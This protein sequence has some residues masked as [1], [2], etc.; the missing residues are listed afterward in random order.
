[1]GLVVA[2][3]VAASGVTLAAQPAR[4]VELAQAV[5]ATTYFV[6]C[7][8][9]SNGAGT[10]SSPWNRLSAV[11][12]H[13]SFS[14]GDRILLKR[15]TTCRGRLTPHGSGAPGAQIVI[16]AYGSGMLPT[17]AGG[18]TPNATG[19]IELHNQQYWTLQNLHVTNRGSAVNPSTYRSGVLVRNDKGGRLKGVVIRKL[20][21]D[22]VWSNPGPKR[23]DYRSW[24]GIS[25]LTTGWERDGFDGL[26]VMNNTI[27]KLGRTGIIVANS[28]FPHGAD[29]GVRIA[30]NRISHVRGDSIIL[31]GSRNARID[32]NVS[33]HG[34]DLGAC[35]VTQCGRRGGPTTASAAIWP[36]LSK[37]VLIEKNEVH[38]E[39]SNSGDGE[40]FDID[41]SASKVVLQH[42]YAHDNEGGGVMFCGASDS[43]V[44]FNVFENNGRAAVTFTC[45]PG[46]KK[47]RIYN[48]TI[49]QKRSVAASYVVITLNGFGVKGTRFFN[50]VVYSYGTSKYRWP[51]SVISSHNTFIGT[52]HASEPKGPGTSHAAPRLRAPGSG[53]VGFSSLKGYRLRTMSKLQRGS[54]IPKSASSDIFG[55][56]VNTSAPIRGAASST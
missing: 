24:G 33:T 4:A 2:A 20:T 9:P 35:S 5:K 32:H 27:G 40:A 23:H 29:D 10:Q 26:Q 13:G 11:S 17:V 55:K 36:I 8:A 31:G 34:G 50:N 46:S 39:Q 43:D 51:G 48:N 6:A 12:Q 49:Y 37:G 44:R 3:G 47:I 52:H 28:E 19:A 53:G 41:R 15:G 18:S 21:I 7:N 38:G 56:G 42:N 45:A 16:D 54:A 22:H 30:G 25:V 14:P 1:M